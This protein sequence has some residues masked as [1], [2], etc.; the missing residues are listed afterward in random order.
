MRVVD[1]TPHLPRGTSEACIIDINAEVDALE[2]VNR[3]L[4]ADL[5][6]Y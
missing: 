1:S 2:M 3:T 5:H 6:G 4:F